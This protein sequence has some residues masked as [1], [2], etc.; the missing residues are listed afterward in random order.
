[1]KKIQITFATILLNLLLFDSPLAEE[2]TLP[3]KT[4]VN[5][6]KQSVEPRDQNI[7]IKVRNDGEQIIVDANFIV[8]VV[9]KQAWAVLTDFENIPRFNSG[10]LSSKVT[11]RTGNRL[12]VWQ[13]GISKYG[14]MSFSYESVREI[15]LI[16]FKKIQE[17][18]ISGS[19][20]K[21][22]EATELSPE[23]NQTRITYHAIF[24]PGMWV[25]P[26]VGNVFIK[27]EAREQF[28]Q[29]IDEIRRRQ[30]NI[31]GHEP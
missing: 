27:H 3:K 24:I 17:R 1:M 18:M 16:P 14:F 26:M 7:H 13:K 23:E 21:M 29:L 9:P 4:S 28:Q 8:P 2:E 25:P 6:A 10:V 12:Q 19:M 20:K 22:E 15:N 5:T 30:M 31:A 11:G